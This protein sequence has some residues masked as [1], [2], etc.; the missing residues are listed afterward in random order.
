MKN[1]EL[2][3]K[4]ATNGLHEST[5]WEGAAATPHQTNLTTTAF[6]PTVPLDTVA[7]ST[8]GN[9]PAWRTSKA[10]RHTNESTPLAKLVRQRLSE[11]GIRQSEFCRAHRFDQGLLSKIQN[12]VITNLSLESV[13]RLSVGLSVP[14]EDLLALVDRMDLHDLVLQAYSSELSTKK[15]ENS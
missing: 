6:R 9:L 5:V 10:S 3:L 11:M 14:P 12:S 13:L 8:N 1:N 15:A 2:F 7:T 4:P